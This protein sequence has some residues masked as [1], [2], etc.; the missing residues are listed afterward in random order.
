M[1]HVV[2][3][4]CAMKQAKGDA[5]MKG[6]F[7]RFTKPGADDV[8]AEVPF[9]NGYNVLARLY[10]SKGGCKNPDDT[11]VGMAGTVIAAAMA[12]VPGAELPDSKALSEEAS[13]LAQLAYD[14]E[15]VKADGTPIDEEGGEPADENPT[16]TPAGRS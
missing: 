13:A 15:L 1:T 4:S 2:Q 11:T 6:M 7:Y 10:L 5:R 8:L 14:V 12:G 9:N 16:G 3:S